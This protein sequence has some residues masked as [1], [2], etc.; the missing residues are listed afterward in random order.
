MEASTYFCH[1]CFACL[2]E[3]ICS[4]CKRPSAELTDEIDQMIDDELARHEEQ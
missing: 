4:L 1:D 3:P 2:L